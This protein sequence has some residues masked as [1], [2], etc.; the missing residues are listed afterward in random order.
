MNDIVEVNKQRRRVKSIQNSRKFTLESALTGTIFSNEMYVVTGVAYGKYSN[1]EGEECIAVGQ[2]SSAIGNHSL[3]PNKAQFSCGEYNSTSA[4]TRFAVGIGSDESNRKNG[5]EVS[6]SGDVK[7]YLGDE[8]ITLQDKIITS[9]WQI[10]GVE[11]AA[12][13]AIA[14]IESS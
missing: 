5:L 13:N 4:D 12:S 7:I 8:Q 6:S 3:S 11:E 9:P 10:P 2:S 14:T 1:V